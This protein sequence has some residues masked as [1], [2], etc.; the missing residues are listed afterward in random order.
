MNLFNLMLIKSYLFTQSLR[1]S[2]IKTITHFIW[3]LCTLC[4]LPLQQHVSCYT[5]RS[6]ERHKWVCELHYDDASHH[7]LH[8]R[9]DSS[10]KNKISYTKLTQFAAKCRGNH[11]EYNCSLQTN[12]AL[13]KHYH[14]YGWKSWTVLEPSFRTVIPDYPNTATKF[15][16]FES[17]FQQ[18]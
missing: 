4:H 13:T 17:L 6:S 2:K 14:L 15:K 3:R 1:R 11:F 10:P 8:K 16:C 18:N 9:C 12:T 5:E 7:K